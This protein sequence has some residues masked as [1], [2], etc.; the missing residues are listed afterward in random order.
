MD[1]SKK[2]DHCIDDADD[3]DIIHTAT[4]F[5]TNAGLSSVTLSSAPH[6]FNI[7]LVTLQLKDAYKN[8]DFAPYIKLPKSKVD[9]K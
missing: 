4:A 3:D 6:L 7:E 8:N 1:A 5:V 9:K 2:I